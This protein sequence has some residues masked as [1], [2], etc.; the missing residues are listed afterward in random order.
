MDEHPENETKAARAYLRADEN[1]C[2]DKRGA[3]WLLKY[4]DYGGK[5]PLTE[6][7]IQSGDIFLLCSDGLTDM[8][9]DDQIYNLLINGADATKL[10]LSAEAAGGL[11]NVSACV[12]KI[13]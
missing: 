7:D 3:Q 9:T 10:C 11:D 13:V 8:V 6:N 2:L 4:I 12:I 1:G 5:L